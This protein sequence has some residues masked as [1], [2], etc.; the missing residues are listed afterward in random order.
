MSSEVHRQLLTNSS[1]K[2]FRRC[3][4][5]Y[6]YKYE[7]GIRPRQRAETLRFGTLIHECLE[8]WWGGIRLGRDGHL[9]RLISAFL[10]DQLNG[11][12]IDAFEHARALELMRGYH[13]RWIDDALANWDVLG[14]EEEFRAPLRNPD[15][16]ASSRTFERAGKLDV[17]VRH[18]DTRREYVFEHKTSTEDLSP[19]SE[20]WE[21]LILDTQISR[22][23]IGARSLGYDVKGCIYDVLK[24]PTL[25][26]Y[27]A[28]AELKL[29]KDG[30]PRAGQRT[31]DETAEEYG[32]RIRNHI[33]ANPDKYYR[34]GEV[35][36]LRHDTLEADRDT[37]QTART[38]RT[39]QSLKEFP[40]NPD[41]CLRFGRRCGF[42]DVCSG[43][44]SI[45]DPIRFEKSEPHSELNT[46]AIAAE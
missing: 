21:R 39:A 9:L 43:T 18:R 38:I 12:Y 14:I 3:P 15:T 26:P 11:G 10:R 5:E 13:Y 36:R 23:M 41:Q 40:R 28:T 17:V 31:A 6:S 29:K 45:D 46:A 8:F 22:Y 1:E 7:Q 35:V 42:F 2:C 4:R 16:G 19:G 24:R 20:Y 44:A 30:T 32:Q 37:W 33:A 25:Q 34:R 27:K